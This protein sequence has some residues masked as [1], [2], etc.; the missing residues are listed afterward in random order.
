MEGR[1]NTPTWCW[2]G[3]QQFGRYYFGLNFLNHARNKMNRNGA[4]G[5]SFRK[6]YIM[7]IEECN[8]NWNHMYEFRIDDNWYPCHIIEENGSIRKSD[9]RV[10]I[11]TRNG[12]IT[13]ERNEDVRKMSEKRYL[14]QRLED[15]GYLGKFSSDRGY[16]KDVEED[17]ELFR[18]LVEL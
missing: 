4:S 2:M 17:L 6:D 10:W 7:T 12:S 9:N 8:G 3:K 5:L 1:K 11:F 14:E 15:M 13:T 16:H 18:G